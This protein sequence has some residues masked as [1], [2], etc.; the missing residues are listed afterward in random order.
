VLE[1]P[2]WEWVEGPAAATEGGRLSRAWKLVRSTGRVADRAVAVAT[3]G[4]R[5]AKWAALDVYAEELA[6]LSGDAGNGRRT[7][8]LRDAFLRSHEVFFRH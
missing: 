2:I 5:D 4:F 1:Y 7:K 8:A 3:E 6:A